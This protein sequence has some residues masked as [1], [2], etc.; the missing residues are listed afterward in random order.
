MGTVNTTELL[1]ERQKTHGEYAEHARCTQELLRVLQS[2]RGWPTLSDIQKESLHMIC[3]KMGRVVT[4]NP[5]I[6]DH[7]DDM[8]GYATLISQRINSPVLPI[9]IDNNIYAA[10]AL[11]WGVTMN[12]A[13]ERY[14]GI[15]AKLRSKPVTTV[16]IA[17]GFVDPNKTMAHEGKL[18]PGSVT[19]DRV[20]GPL[21]TETND[22]LVQ[23]VAAAI[24]DTESTK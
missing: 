4:G 23:A 19:N 3:H 14:R 16:E 18:A 24:A 10:L 13:A 21:P 22:P 20:T 9:D 11:G 15:V 1:A 5:D 6:A 2:E 17:T 12:E 7:W 8:A